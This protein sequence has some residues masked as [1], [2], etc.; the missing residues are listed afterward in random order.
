MERRCHFRIQALHPILYYEH[1]HPRPK[2]GSTANLSLEGV[3][4][5]TR[6]PLTKGELLEI[7]IA[8]GSGLI[9]CSGK[10]IYV[11]ALKGKKF[12]A[13]IRL[14]EISEKTRFVLER[15]LSCAAR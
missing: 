12:K 1:T 8:L 15:Y 6:H 2:S 5:Q 7:S 9:S 4:L 14:E 10:V 13:G 11:Q 3:A